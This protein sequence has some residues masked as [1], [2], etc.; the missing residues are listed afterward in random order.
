MAR[1]GGPGPA[2]RVR[3]P[4]REQDVQSQDGRWQHERERHDPLDQ[5]LA[6]P[7]REGEPVRDG[8]ADDKKDE[9]DDRGE[10]DA[11][12]D[13]SPVHHSRLTAKPKSASSFIE[14][15]CFRNSMK[16][17]ATCACV[18]LRR[19]TTAWRMGG[20][21]VDGISAYVPPDLSAGASA[22]DSAMIPTW[23][24]P[25]CANCAACEMFSPST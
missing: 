9:R 10:S 13:R 1:P 2:D 12:R 11:Q 23:A 3:G 14:S 20:C 8:E 16:W 15:G 21:I 6:T 19:T 5:K 22:T 18:A 24:L 25:D 4:D 17:R 7:L